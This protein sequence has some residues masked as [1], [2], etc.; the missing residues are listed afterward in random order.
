M[1]K[2][3]LG[4]QKQLEALLKPTAVEMSPERLETALLSALQPLYQRLQSLEQAQN[5]STD[6]LTQVMAQ[7]QR[8]ELMLQQLLAALQ[9]SGTTASSTTLDQQLQPLLTQLSETSKHL[10][11]SA[12]AFTTLLNSIE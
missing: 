12:I 1:P 3:K 8:Q 4:R 5:Q 7:T 6:L 10:H 2:T 9:Q 11:H